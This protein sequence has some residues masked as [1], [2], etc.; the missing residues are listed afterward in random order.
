MMFI[1]DF[2]EWISFGNYDCVEAIHWRWTKFRWGGRV[3]ELK[4]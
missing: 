2:S 4:E 3:E 1:N